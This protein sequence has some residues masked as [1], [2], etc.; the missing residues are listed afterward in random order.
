MTLQCKQ[1]LSESY[2]IFDPYISRLEHGIMFQLQ[3][4][5]PPETEM[6]KQIHRYYLCKKVYCVVIVWI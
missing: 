1:E 6:M 4:L 3:S 5:Q 2:L